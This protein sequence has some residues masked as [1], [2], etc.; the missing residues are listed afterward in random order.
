VAPISSADVGTS[1]VS[2]TEA[3]E[4]LKVATESA[5]LVASQDAAAESD[6]DDLMD[7]L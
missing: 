2:P 5:P 4:F 3:A 7:D 1:T 6:E